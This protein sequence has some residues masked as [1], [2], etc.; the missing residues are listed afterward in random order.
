MRERSYFWLLVFSIFLI[1][2]LTGAPYYLAHRGAGDDQVFGGFLMNPLDGNT[3]LAK[4]Y[5]GLQGQWKYT[6]P[7]SADQGDG[8]Y[9]F[10]FYLFLG[11][12][13]RITGISLILLFHLA[14]LIAAAIMLIAIYRF[15]QVVVTE[16]T[17][18]S[19]AFILAV[20]GSGMGWLA[21]VAGEITSDF[22][23]AEAYPFL[24]AYTNPH[25]SLGIGLTLLLITPILQWRA[26]PLRREWATPFLAFALVIVYPFGI[27]LVLLLL[28]AM[29]FWEQYL[30]E[31]RTLPRIYHWRFL[32]TLIMSLPVLVYY[33]LIV[34]TDPIF[35]AWNAQN[36]TPSPG[37]V[38]FLVSFSPLI[39]I[40][41]LGISGIIK[42][43]PGNIRV[44][45]LWLVLGIVLLYLPWS[46]QRRFIYGLYIP[47]AILAAMSL[48]KILTNRNTIRWVGTASIVLAIPTNIII[49]LSA[50]QGIS[51]H[52]PSIYIYRDEEQAF[53][54]IAM[55]TPE[56]AVIIAAPD[57]GLFIPAQTGRRVIYGHP[58][59]T[60]NAEAQ[61]NR[62]TRFFIGKPS[63]GDINPL[64]QGD[65]LF[66]GPREMELGKGYLP[67]G[68]VLVYESG[69]TRVYQVIH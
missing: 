2:I 46:L 27:I 63:T 7:Y 41:I 57:T 65:Y 31:E 24:S 58:F 42:Q 36:L 54:W 6:L 47:I 55:N 37:I 38:D 25:F 44:V 66:Y 33:L 52:N 11:H 62:L 9:F 20:F 13:A 23:V 64:T 48:N 53:Q 4:M 61:K 56:D 28:G 16:R 29:V 30:A 59:E 26:S 49:L 21:L 69:S 40:V 10:I 51:T 68:L 35:S 50:G 17:A 1:I 22:W 32:I 43:R 18:R 39:L 34:F 19:T 15:I 45:I 60:I 8:A 14:R 67:D 12:I 5:Q 3:Y